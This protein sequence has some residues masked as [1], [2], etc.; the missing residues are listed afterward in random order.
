MKRTFL[1]ILL[2]LIFSVSTANG[3]TNR[4]YSCWNPPDNCVAA[5]PQWSND[6][7]IVTLTNNCLGRIYVKWCYEVK[8]SMKPDC[9]STSLEVG[10]HTGGL[11]S[12]RRTGRYKVLY[13]GVHESGHEW[14]CSDRVPGWKA[15]WNF[16]DN[17]PQQSEVNNGNHT[18]SAPSADSNTVRKSAAGQGKVIIYYYIP[19]EKVSVRNWVT[20]KI[21][22]HHSGKVYPD[23]LNRNPDCDSKGGVTLELPVGI[24]S[25]TLSTG[26]KGAF[27][28]K[29]GECRQIQVTDFPYT[30]IERP[31]TQN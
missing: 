7:F 30:R 25:Y 28:L 12:K 14:S 11:D 20:F 31:V 13:T 5:T 10:K 21:D 29:E 23:Y 19:Q 27:K 15:E 2:F 4:N 8:D 16:V 3:E 22:D 1:V 9:Y 17:N 24:H 18:G 26:D 6:R